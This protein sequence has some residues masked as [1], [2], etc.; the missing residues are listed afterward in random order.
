MK[1]FLL[2]IF[3]LVCLGYDSGLCGKPENISLADAKFVSKSLENFSFKLFRQ[4]NEQDENVVFSP[5]SIFGAFSILAYGSVG[6]SFNQLSD[7]LEISDFREVFGFQ[8]SLIKKNKSYK[9]FLV[10][11]LFLD[12]QIPLKTKFR[13]TILSYGPGVKKLNFSQNPGDCIRF[14]NEWIERQ[15]KGEITNFVQPGDVGTLTR[16]VILNILS[17]KAAWERKFDL[18][19]TEKQPFFL[20]PENQVS[21]DMMR[22]YSQRC[23]IGIINKKE[24]G[25]DDMTVVAVPFQDYKLSLVIIMP[26]DAGNF[27]QLLDDDAASRLRNVF[28][29]MRY[30]NDGEALFYQRCE[31]TLPKF[32]VNH[33]QNSLSGIMKSIGIVDVFDPFLANLNNLTRRDMGLYVNDAVHEAK[34]KIDE[35]GI[36]ASAATGIYINALSLPPSIVI[37]KPFVFLLRHEETGAILF[38]GKVIDPRS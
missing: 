17:V 33:K 7:S 2:K 36:K 23:S 12:K 1:S 16:L 15:T 32:E 14:I 19:N 31:L 37:N 25:F 3:L 9:L 6:E 18:T 22:S 21:S 26:K 11:R 20:S 28:E 35:E 38:M 13:K 4:F 5:L 10:E 29:S 30:D 8:K 34:F 27:E 24:G